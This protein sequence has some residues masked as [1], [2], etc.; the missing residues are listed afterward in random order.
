M[1]TVLWFTAAYT[2]GL[3]AYGVAMDSPLTYVY[4]G[5]TVLVIGFFL[6]IDRWAE[7]EVWVWWGIS[8][9][10][11]GNMLGGVLLVDGEPL[12]ISAV[13]GDVR[14][15]KVFHVLAAMVMFFVAWAAMKKFAGEI[16]HRGG[17]LLFTFLVVMGGG[18]VVEIAELIGGTI[19]D[20]NVGDY[21]NNA[22]DMVANAV[23]ALAGL[24]IVLW[25]ERSPARN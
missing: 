20:V 15:D 9:V 18:A 10:G 12:Y 1:K 21:G 11:L 22:L 4:T 25:V 6:A 13:F 17:L 8:L 7:F 3:F 14:Y 16:Q 24:L 23:G 2:V 19:G 5:I